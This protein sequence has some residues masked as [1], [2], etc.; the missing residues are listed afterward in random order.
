MLD[1]LNALLAEPRRGPGHHRSSSTEFMR[2]HGEFFPENPQNTDELVDLLAAAGRG[3][4]ADAQLDERR[5]AR[6]AGRAGPAGVR[7]PRG[8][9]RRWPSS[10][11]SCRACG[12][13]EDWDGAGPV[14]RRQPDGHGRGHPGDG[15]ARPARRAGRAA[16]AELPRRAAGGHRPRRARG[17]SWATQARVDARALAE[18]ERELRAPGPLRARCPTARCGCRRRR[19]GGWGS[20]RCATSS[21]SS[22]S[23]AGRA[24]DPPLRGGGRSRPGAT[25]PWAFGDTEA[26]HVPRTL[27]TP[28]LRRA[29]GDAARGSTSPTWRSSRPSSAP[30]PRWRCASTPRGRWCRT[31]AGCR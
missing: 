7:R 3:R 31:G 25:R 16:G 20:P 5:A 30:G 24:G 23:P 22:S 27:P 14:P 11:R 28:Q 17:A 15:G 26:W 18:L 8:S 6:R 1:D 10:T 9:P 29:G 19:C 12:P 4:A 13:G 21:T 2:Q